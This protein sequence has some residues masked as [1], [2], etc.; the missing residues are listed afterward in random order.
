M[1]SVLVYDAVCVLVYIYTHGVIIFSKI[2][3]FST[4]YVVLMC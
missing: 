1:H 3:N 2:W 4:L